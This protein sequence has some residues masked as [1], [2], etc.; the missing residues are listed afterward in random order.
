ME[1]WGCDF[2]VKTILPLTTCLCS[3][4]GKEISRIIWDTADGISSFEGQ[5]GN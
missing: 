4:W 2:S 1:A 3:I 5:K